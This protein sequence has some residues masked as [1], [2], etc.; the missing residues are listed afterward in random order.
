MTESAT[1]SQLRLRPTL[2]FRDLVLYYVVTTISIVLVCVP[3]DDEPNKMLAVITMVGSSVVL[4][5]MG[6]LVYVIGRRR[7]T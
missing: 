4:V 1:S 3:P 5:A 7:Q 2:G 6:A